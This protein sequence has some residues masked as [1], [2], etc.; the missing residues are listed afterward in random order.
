MYNRYIPTAEG[1][2]R[3]EVITTANKVEPPPCPREPVSPAPQALPPQQSC[4]VPLLPIHLDMQD[5]LVLL[6]LVLLLL[7]GGSGDGL[8]LLITMAAFI[9]LQ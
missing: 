2:Y 5:I 3:R 9:L 6:V 7:Q 4:T 8:S 1:T